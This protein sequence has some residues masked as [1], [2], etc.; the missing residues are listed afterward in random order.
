MATPNVLILRAPG[1]N[2]D[3]ETAFAFETAGAK[4]E[5]V[6]VNRLLEEPN[7]FDRFQI[8][9]IPGGFSYGDDVA[10]G[11]ILANQI[12]HHLSDA[13]AR[14]KDAG[15]LIL[16]ICNGFQVLIRSGVLLDGNA[17]QGSPAT[18]TW[19]DS[20]R[21]EDRW[22]RLGTDGTKCVFF[23]DVE[24]MY[25]PVAHAEG[26]FVARDEATLNRLAAAGQLVLRYLPLD[27]GMAGAKRSA[28]WL[29]HSEAVPQATDILPFPDNPNGSQANVAGVCDATGRVLGLMPHPERHIT[30][31]QHPRWTRPETTQTGDGL[32]LFENAVAYFA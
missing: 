6:H 11:R 29:G 13:M 16:G 5:R 24:R 1:T 30:R 3:L 23:K 27:G 10:A 22:V 20:G 12:I 4:T 25:L 2:C 9:C 15:K 8:L 28:G 21:Y 26:K 17:E 31:T 7:R 19:N 18:L 14:F 32:K